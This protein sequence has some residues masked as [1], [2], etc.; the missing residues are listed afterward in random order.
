MI[1]EILT[2]LPGLL[3]VYAICALGLLSPGPNVLSVIGT[4]MDAGRGKAMAVAWGVSLGTGIWASC[5]VVGLTALMTRYA[6]LA[7]AIRIAGGC[8]LLWLAF[9]SFRA[10]LGSRE[11]NSVPSRGNVSFRAAF[12]RGLAIQMTN[13]KAALTWASIMTLVIRPDVPSW[14]S[15]AVVLGCTIVSAFGHSLYALAFSSTHVVLGY[16][17]LRRMIEGALA[18]FF[19]FAGVRLI[20]AR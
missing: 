11:L 20:V 9:K 6:E 8:Y 17:R 16:R 1:Q 13:P 3:A 10:A 14:V 15:I 5:T 19:C 4:A 7:L 2:H 12:A 18:L